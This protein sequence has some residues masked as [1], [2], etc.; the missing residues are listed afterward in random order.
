MAPAAPTVTTA[1]Y[2]GAAEPIK[3]I[4]L[5]DVGP[6]L[7][8][9]DLQQILGGLPGFVK[10]NLN[11][12]GTPKAACFALFDSP[13]NASTALEYA[14]AYQAP[15]AKGTFTVEMARANLYKN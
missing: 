8:E 7:T 13:E 5:A 4:R 9:V 6:G 14:S 10:L 12:P 3:T 2:G 15:T 1:A 11:R